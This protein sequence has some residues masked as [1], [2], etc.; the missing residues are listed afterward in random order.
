MFGLHGTQTIVFSRDF[1]LH[2]TMVPEPSLQS[3]PTIA[4]SMEL[5]LLYSPGIL[6]PIDVSC[7]RVADTDITGDDALICGGEG[8]TGHLRQLG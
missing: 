4:V 5:K 6:A 3:F 8:T 7:K 1:G 2:G